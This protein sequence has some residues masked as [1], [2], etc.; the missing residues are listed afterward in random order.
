MKTFFTQPIGNL[1]R[2][3]AILFLAINVVFIAVEF[4]GITALDGIEDLLNFVWGFSLASIII[5]AYYLAEGH[6]PEYWRS[7]H[8][9]LATVIILGTFLEITDYLDGGFLPMYLSLIHI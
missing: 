6:V 1:S 4:S 3:N 9:I 8:T 7:A 5:G 2:Q